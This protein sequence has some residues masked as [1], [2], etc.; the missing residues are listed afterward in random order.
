MGDA[1]KEP[2]ARV[3][4]E[5][6]IEGSKALHL[7]AGKAYRSMP[8]VYF[9]LPIYICVR[10]VLPCQD[11]R[12]ILLLARCSRS[13]IA[14]SLV[15]TMKT[16][17]WI[18]FFSALGVADANWAKNI[19]YRSPSEHHP[20][21]GISIRKVVKRNDLSSPWDPAQLNFTQYVSPSPSPRW[22]RFADKRG[23]ISFDVSGVASG[24]PYPNSVILWTRVGPSSD[25]DQSNVTVSGYVPLYDH[26]TEQY[27]SMSTAPVCVD[28]TVASDEALT[29][30][31]TS[32][33]V[34]TSSDVDYTVKVRTA[35]LNDHLIC[36][37]RATNT[38]GRRK[39]QVEATGLSPFTTY[40]YQFAVCNSDNKSPLGRTKT[41]P[42]VDDDVTEIGIAVYSCSNYRKRQT[43]SLGVFSRLTPTNTSC[44]I[45]LLQRVRQPGPEG[46]GRLRRPSRRLH[47][48]IQKRRLRLGTKPR[49]HPAARQG[50]L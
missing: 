28:F 18:L 30:V 8:F 17:S 5:T 31:V 10:P 6:N 4:G 22:H 49:P 9:S 50:D 45:R 14:R 32:G 7:H 23:R 26:G 24:D 33:T 11:C 47:L 29:N 46:L 20:S 41:T 40:Y 13:S 48:R 25:N 2:A 21:L 34:Y 36:A 16:N 35:W 42:D 39:R 37:H 44:S 38:H 15:F 3:L 43:L 1:E 27:V 12:E 19:N